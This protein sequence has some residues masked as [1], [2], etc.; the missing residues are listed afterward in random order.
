LVEGTSEPWGPAD[1]ATARLIGDTVTD[2]VIQ[3]RS[4]RSLIAEDQLDQV[5]RQLQQAGNPVVITD[6]DG[7][8]LQINS[9]FDALLPPRTKRPASV[10]DLLSLFSG[11]DDAV[12]ALE[13]LVKSRRAWRGE[14][15]MDG[16]QTPLLVRAD[17]VF[18]PQARMLGFV[19]MFTDLTG[20][21]AAETARK[22]FQQGVIEQHRPVMGRLDSKSDLVFRN[23][24]STMVENAQLAALEI[25]D[26]V[27]PAQMPEMLEAIR[28]SVARTAEMLGYLIWHSSRGEKG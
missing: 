19:L 2:V 26:G 9:A 20:R 15:I 13:A 8:I 12:L 4:V 7:V 27:D 5:R 14:V 3:F 11:P 25:A 6:P 18:A 10:S 21:K 17:P 22:R 1:L 28:Q 16:K 24:L 23:L